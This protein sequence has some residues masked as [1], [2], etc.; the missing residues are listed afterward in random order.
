[1]AACGACAGALRLLQRTAAK[2]PAPEET[3]APAGSEDVAIR[4]EPVPH[5]SPPWWS[6]LARTLLHPA[7]AA[8]YLLLLVLSVPIYRGWISAPEEA[9][10]P[11]WGGSVD[12]H[13]LTSAMRGGA[14]VPTVEVEEGQ[15]VVALGAEFELPAISGPIRFDILDASGEVAWREEASADRVRGN[16]DRSGIVTLL[17]P[18]HRVPP[19]A[20]QLR[21]EPEEGAG[22]R[23]LLE[24]PFQVSYR[25]SPAATNAPQ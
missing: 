16:L 3:E 4:Q 15:P 13:V 23:P 9:A 24:A 25:Q 17:I 14:S 21:V 6:F 10:V 5:L 20:Y 7:A 11:P 19:G 1:V 12:L 8:A 18:S 2:E 22:R